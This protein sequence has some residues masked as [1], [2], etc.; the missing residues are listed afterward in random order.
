[1]R[2]RIK[3]TILKVKPYVGGKPIEEVKREMGL[4]D[5]IKL[6]SNENPYGPS[7]KVLQAIRAAAKD[8][9]RYPDGGCFYLRQA[10]AKKLRV[11]PAQL[12]FGN[13]SDE[14]IILAIRA[15]VEEGEEVVMAKPSFLVYSIA[16][17]IAGAKIRAV[18]L[19]DFRYDL[20][21]MRRVITKKTKI[22]FLGNPDNPSGYYIPQKE[23]KQFIR[24]L[25]K[26]VLVFIDEAYFEYVRPKDYGNS[27]DLLKTFKNVFLTRTFSK[28]YGLAGLRVGYGVGSLDLVDILNRIREP[29]NV[30]SLAQVG[31]LACLKDQGYYRK[32][33][34]T[35]EKE[36]RYVY[37][38]LERLGVP[39]RESYTNFILV[40]VNNGTKVARAL[41]KKGVIVRDMAFW[42]LKKYIRVSIGKH[43]E[44]RKFIQELEKIL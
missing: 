28:M 33:A 9:N 18:P 32:V 14:L 23:L 36:R 11:K 40:Q 30:N 21:G 37:R 13:G 39:Y 24:S 6:A 25:P 10:L 42:G 4:K 38:S 34:Q 17:R 3:K 12:I 44:N 1:M 41:L 8:L 26:E 22:V 7:P 19:K 5:V 35:I 43:L 29:F 2:K 27:L 31:A 15:F 20:A 16:S